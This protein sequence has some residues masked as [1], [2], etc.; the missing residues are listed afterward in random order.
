MEGNNLL[1][2]LNLL[3]TKMPD[4]LLGHVYIE[5]LPVGMYIVMQ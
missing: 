5:Q 3:V 1:Q 4:G 2:F